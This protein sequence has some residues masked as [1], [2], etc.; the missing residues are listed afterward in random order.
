MAVA[1][2]ATCWISRLKRFAARTSSRRDRRAS[3]RDSIPRLRAGLHND[4]C[5]THQPSSVTTEEVAMRH[6][7]L[8]LILTSSA[9]IFIR[10]ENRTSA[11]LARS[12][13]RSLQNAPLTAFAAADP[14]RRGQFVAALYV[15]EQLLVIVAAHPD[16]SAIEARITA[17]QYRD[18][19]LDLQGTPSPQGRFFVV[20]A[21]AD[22]LLASPPDDGG[23]DVVY[24]G[25]AQPLLLNGELGPR[26]RNAGAYDAAVA[27]AETK[28]SHALGVLQAAFETRA[29]SR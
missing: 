10:A 26:R 28:Y 6:V 15:P 5:D 16:V 3:R 4:L 29:G 27:A 2:G 9:E 19:Y 20:D 17:G 7:L 11:G 8:V 14:D 18:V 22:G 13:V 25:S 23:V 24:D 21:D 12:V 1:A